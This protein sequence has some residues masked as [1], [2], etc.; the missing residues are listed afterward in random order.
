MT[1]IGQNP[2]SSLPYPIYICVTTGACKHMMLIM[3][4]CLVV[5]SRLFKVG[6]LARAEHGADAVPEEQHI[7]VPTSKWALQLTLMSILRGGVSE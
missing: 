7:L 6:R 3:V 1:V 2:I 4:C 5:Q